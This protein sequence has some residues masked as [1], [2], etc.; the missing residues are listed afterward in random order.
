MH[1]QDRNRNG[2]TG[3]GG[4]LVIHLDTSA[5]VKLYLL[6]DDSEMA[7]GLIVTQDDPLPT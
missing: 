2:E 1:R 3:S 5:L 6:E 4:T 7:R